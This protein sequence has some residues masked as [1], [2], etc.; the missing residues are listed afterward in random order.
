FWIVILAHVLETFPYMV[1][2]TGAVLQRM[3]PHLES[4]ARSLGAGRFRVFWTI[5]LPRLRPGLVAGVVLVFSRSIAE[6]GAT[7]IVVSA[8]L[9]RGPI[10]IYD[11]A[12]AGS[13]ELA[14]AYSVILMCASFAAHVLMSRGLDRSVT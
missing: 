7:I 11:E 8:A 9:R 5:T 2:A 12:E 13:L 6:F 10:A 3:E 14:S 4:A 1:R